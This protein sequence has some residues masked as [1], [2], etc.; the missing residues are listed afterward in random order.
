MLYKEIGTQAACDYCADVMSKMKL[1]YS[2]ARVFYFLADPEPW[3]N[4]A[5]LLKK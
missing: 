3:L 1:K 4:F 2:E 5:N